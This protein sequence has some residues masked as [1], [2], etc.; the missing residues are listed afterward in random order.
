M[1]VEP[2]QY[3]MAV[4]S[5]LRHVEG[6][7]RPYHV[8]TS[9]RFMDLVMRAIR[10]LR[11]RLNTRVRSEQVIFQPHQV[12]LTRT[13]LDT[14]D[15]PRPIRHATSVTQSTAEVHRAWNPRR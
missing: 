7:L 2:H 15:T 1:L 14:A 5:A 13:F 3:D 9:E 12:T 10:K 4:R 8:I 11:S 6:G